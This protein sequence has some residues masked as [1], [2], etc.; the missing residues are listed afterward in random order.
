MSAVAKSLFL[1][2]KNVGLFNS[3]LGQADDTNWTIS[4]LQPNEKVSILAIV[5]D[6]TLT[7]LW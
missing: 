7:I 6:A 3:K 1:H 5:N 4:W 2:P